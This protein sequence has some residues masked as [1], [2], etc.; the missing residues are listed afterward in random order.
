MAGIKSGLFEVVLA[1][2]REDAI[3]EIQAVAGESRDGFGEFWDIGVLRF[4]GLGLR[5]L[6]GSVKGGEWGFDAEAALAAAALGGGFLRSGEGE[7][8]KGDEGRWRMEVTTR[9]V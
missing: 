8:T 4:R 1:D 9:W 5:L 2:E 6:L 7:E 3:V